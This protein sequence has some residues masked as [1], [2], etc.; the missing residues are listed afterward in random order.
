MLDPYIL[1]T[2]KGTKEKEKTHQELL[3]VLDPYVLLTFKGT[4]EKEK[5]TRSSWRCWILTS[6]LLLKELRKKKKTPQERLE[7]LDPYVLL[8]FKGTV[9]VF[10]PSP[11]FMFTAEQILWCCAQQTPFCSEGNQDR[12]AVEQ[13]LLKFFDTTTTFHV[14]RCFFSQQPPFMPL[15]VFA[16]QLFYFIPFCKR[17]A[18]FIK[19]SRPE[20]RR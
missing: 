11:H 5:I 14:C 12:E 10:A 8:T 6:S 19:G 20:L 15:D 13:C 2:L 9:D 3:E 4:K 1:L 17:I 18:Y 16:Q 7:V